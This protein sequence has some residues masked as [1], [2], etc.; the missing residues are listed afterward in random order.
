LV[1]SQDLVFQSTIFILILGVIGTAIANVLF[2][3][4]LQLSSPL[5]ASSV[6]YLIPVVALFWGIYFMEKL[7]LIQFFAV[8]IILFGVWLSS[9]KKN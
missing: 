2:F 4:L 5:F 8:I 6:T 1:I 3:K 9:R 7:S